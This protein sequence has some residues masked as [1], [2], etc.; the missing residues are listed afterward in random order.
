MGLS[1][2]L[3]P[4]PPNCGYT[5]A[6][7]LREKDQGGEISRG[8]GGQRWTAASPGTQQARKEE[9]ASHA[10]DPS[11]GADMEGHGAIGK[12]LGGVKTLAVRK[13]QAGPFI[14]EVWLE[15]AQGKFAGSK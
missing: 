10:H 3:V 8:L 5:V 14:M 12:D 1:T 2:R 4:L 13:V 7:A 9:A 6:I 15:E 11:N